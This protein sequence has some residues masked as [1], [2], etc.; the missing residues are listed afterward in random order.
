MIV[1]R[2][3]NMD[4]IPKIMAFIDEHWKK[5]HILAEDIDFFEWQFVENR[6][7]NMIVA[8]EDNKIYGIQG[9]IPY[10]HTKHPDISGSIWKTIKS[11]NP[12]LG[13]DMERKI[14]EITNFRWCGS[15][16]LSDKALKIG[17]IQGM[18]VSRLGHFYRIGY[19]DNFK[20]AKISMLERQPYLKYEGVCF[21]DLNSFEKFEEI[22]SDDY[23]SSFLPYK[24]LL[25]FKNRYFLHPVYSYIVKGIQMENG[26]MKSRM[27]RGQ[28]FE[29]CGLCWNG[30]GFRV[31]RI[32][33]R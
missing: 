20:I 19:T 12:L 29:N 1:I 24:D 22:F 10:N 2:R 6:Q 5:G 13:M 26:A 16:G 32:C 7:V 33:S 11:G 4:D 3:A 28:D 21:K 31:Y 18:T 30:N 25:Y 17:L 14:K 9:Y 15:C 8:V 23:L 27:S